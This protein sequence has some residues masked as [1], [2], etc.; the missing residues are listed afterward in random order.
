MQ[1]QQALSGPHMTVRREAG[2]AN[3][4][5]LASYQ[6]SGVMPRARA[7]RPWVSAGCSVVPVIDGRGSDAVRAIGTVSTGLLH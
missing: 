4:T 7:T 5:P 1:R 3:R 2:E 6:H